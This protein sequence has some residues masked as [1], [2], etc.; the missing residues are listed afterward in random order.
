M[1]LGCEG[2]GVGLGA[3]GAENRLHKGPRWDWPCTS[4]N[5][6]ETEG[7]WREIGEGLSW[8][9]WIDPVGSAP[10]PW[11]LDDSRGL[12]TPLFYRKGN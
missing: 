4:R 9:G 11:G 10:G 2:E 7:G 1:P 3:S 6:P 5:S 12:R 8:D